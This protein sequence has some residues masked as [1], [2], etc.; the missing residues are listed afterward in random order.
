[1][2]LVCSLCVDTQ[3][4]TSSFFALQLNTFTMG[5]S[6]FDNY[7][8]AKAGIR[9]QMGALTQDQT[10]KHCENLGRTDV[11]LQDSHVPLRDPH[12]IAGT[13]HKEGDAFPPYSSQTTGTAEIKGHQG[14][15]WPFH[16]LSTAA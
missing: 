2:V 11:P 4:F 3:A 16:V 12:P 6:G 9:K 15:G 1:M 5:L 10:F 13:W 14:A 8:A 7:Q